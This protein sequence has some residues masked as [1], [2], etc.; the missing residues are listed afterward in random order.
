MAMRL[1]TRGGQSD[2]QLLSRLCARAG[3]TVFS[4][5]FQSTAVAA[6]HGDSAATAHG[7]LYCH[8]TIIGDVQHHSTEQPHSSTLMTK[9]MFSI[10]PFSSNRYRLQLRGLVSDRFLILYHVLLFSVNSLVVNLC[11]PVLYTRSCWVVLL[12]L[13]QLDILS[14]WMNS[15][16]LL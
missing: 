3:S 2:I 5:R 13:D 16:S 11:R 7:K 8:C 10:F 14:C 6:A 9:L 15:P 12:M 1:L 4:Y